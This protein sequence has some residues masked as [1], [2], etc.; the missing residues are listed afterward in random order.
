MSFCT[1]FANIDDS[2]LPEGI[3]SDL[4]C[5]INYLVESAGVRTFFLAPNR[6]FE[7][8]CRNI[9]ETVS[10]CL[11]KEIYVLGSAEKS[12]YD[13]FLSDKLI[14]PRDHIGDYLICDKSTKDIVLAVMGA[15]YVVERPRSKT[16]LLVQSHLILK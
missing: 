12:T 15:D 13:L 11:H 6:K 3:E 4:F 5:I 8:Q 16:Y 2:E 1:V 14:S 7:E 9:I 10:D